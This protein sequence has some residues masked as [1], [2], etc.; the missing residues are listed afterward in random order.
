MCGFMD[1]FW[2]KFTRLGLLKGTFTFSLPGDRCVGVG[3]GL[4]TFRGGGGSL[5]K[6]LGHRGRGLCSCVLKACERDI[7]WGLRECNRRIG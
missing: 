1:E 4:Y 5:S 2:K 3:G 6:A 7:W